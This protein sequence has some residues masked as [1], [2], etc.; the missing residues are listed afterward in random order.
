[1]VGAT[2]VVIGAGGGVG[3]AL[4]EALAR[5]GRY[6]RVHALSRDPKPDE[7]LIAEGFID[8]TDEAS[9]LH[10]ADGLGPSLDLVVISTGILHEGGMMPEKALRELDGAA[11][12]R[13]FVLNTIG[14]ALVLKHFSPRLAK[15][16]RAVIAALSARVG[17]IS[18]N[19]SGGWYSYRASKAALNMIIKSAAIE[20]AR[21]RPK[22]VCVAIHPGTVD[23]ALS[24]PFRRGLKE[25]QLFTRERAAT[26]ILSVLEN[27]QPEQSGRMF[28]WDGSEIAP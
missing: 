17:S 14:P 1:M 3:S 13:T 10:A 11:L 16:R 7:G 9:I 22:A 25:G 15:D 6:S 24:M 12:A 18:D 21:S 26:Q 20:I 5:S 27:I 4:V 23:T 28:A 8:V 2:A 19:R